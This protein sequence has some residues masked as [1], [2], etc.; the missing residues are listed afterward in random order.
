MRHQRTLGLSVE[1]LE[2]KTLLSAAHA[3]VALPPPGV[4][5]EV[6]HESKAGL[7]LAQSYLGQNGIGYGQQ[8]TVSTLW[9]TKTRP[10]TAP[11]Y[12]NVVSVFNQELA[13]QVAGKGPLPIYH[14]SVIVD[15]S[16][17]GFITGESFH[18]SANKVSLDLKFTAPSGYV[19]VEHYTLNSVRIT[20]PTGS[21][22]TS[23]AVAQFSQAL[24]GHVASG[25]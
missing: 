8:Y 4:V 6:F 22:S 11:N 14:G 21:F 20:N 17:D 1:P 24:T 25:K 12:A 13:S 19:F 9:N 16:D 2:G 18:Q 23:Q 10:T 3:A 7:S 5:H 15:G